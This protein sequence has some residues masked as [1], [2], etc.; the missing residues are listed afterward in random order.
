MTSQQLLEQVKFEE[1]LRLQKYLCSAGHWTIGYGRNMDADPFFEGN[2][3][4]NQ[5]AADE[6]EA[7][8][9]HDLNHAATVLAAAWHG[10]ELL[11]GARRDAVI[12][13]CFQLGLDGFLGFKKMRAA[14]L[15]CDW[16]AAYAE[17]MDSKW[18]KQDSPSRAARVAGQFLSGNYYLVPRAGR[19]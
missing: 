4:P 7:I 1:G 6:A 14:L 8:L 13:M 5:I 15:R 2:R 16:Q 11:Q 17:A 18:G 3:I 12:Q 10:Y 19:S 9:F